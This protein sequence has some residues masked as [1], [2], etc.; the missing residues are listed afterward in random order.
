MTR[1]HAGNVA[2]SAG[3]D[4]MDQRL[5]LLHELAHW[6][7]LPAR[8]PRRRAVHHDAAFYSAAF[9]LYQRHGIPDAVAL[10]GESARYPS[11]L[12]HARWLGVPGADAAWH[13]RRAALRDARRARGPLRVL[14]PEHRVSLVRDGRWTRCATCGVRVVGP[15]LRRLRR[16]GGRHVLLSA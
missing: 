11:A 16:R 15:V 14:V 9:A 6:L 5:T 2:V 3:L 12:R 1:R 7:T 4:Q 8:G 13:D 10:R